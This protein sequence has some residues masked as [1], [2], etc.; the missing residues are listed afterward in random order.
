M[1][2][3]KKCAFY[4]V[5]LLSAVILISCIS[6]SGFSP[7]YG[8]EGTEVTIQGRGFKSNPAQNTVKFGGVS[9][10]LADI[11]YASS[12]IIKA[13]VPAGAG[14]GFIS[15]SNSNGTARSKENF[16]MNRDSK[17]TFLVY[18][19]ADN[20]LE[21]AGLDD[22]RE[23]AAVG[24]SDQLQIVVQ[25]DRI[26]GYST[27]DGDWEGT[28]RFH[29]QPGDDPSGVPVSDLGEIN[30]GDPDELQD[31]IEW[32][33]TNYPSEHYALII[34]NHGDGFR[35]FMEER[36]NR[37]RSLS[38]GDAENN[39]VA[40]YRAVASDTTDGDELYM[41]EVQEAVQ[42]ARTRS[43]TNLKLD[44]IGFDACLMGM[45]E[46]AYA[47]RGSADYIVFSEDCE[48]FDGWPYDPILPVL[49][50]DPAVSGESL[51]IKIVTEYFISYPGDN[52]VTQS[53]V[54]MDQL[55]ALVG[56]I[57]GFTKVA[58]SE[59]AALKQARDNTVE[60]HAC[61]W[62]SSCWGTDIH[63]FMA[64][65]IAEVSSTEIQQAALAVQQAVNNFVISE[66]HG[67]DLAGSK[68]I[69]IY[70]PPDLTA[71]NNDPDHTGYEDSNTFM[72]VDFV[73][74]NQWDNWLQDFYA[75]IP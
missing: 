51:C 25:M 72:V 10:P 11:T 35:M 57:N 2:I 29:I 46:V 44:V 6:I 66:Q 55:D 43:N 27:A 70:F 47:L 45:V 9:V 71:F 3:K 16:I 54:D 13:L 65:V 1:K 48:P 15:V 12:T 14:T 41:K 33:V 7:D 60:Y 53:A 42:G 74:N 38:A 64:N 58:T 8:E 73:A 68:G 75:N 17:W 32:G 26:A 22:F 52:D 67:S 30:M 40:L 20:N 18:L 21:S 5:S 39:A 23:M 37:V 49:D 31:F 69:A 56:S 28:R 59:W 63:H 62:S 4:L 24:S 34:W 61:C 19:D 36:M 50:S